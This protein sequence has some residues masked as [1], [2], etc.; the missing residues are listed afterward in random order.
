MSNSRTHV[1]KDSMECSVLFKQTHSIKA[2]HWGKG[3]EIRK[4]KI[5]Y[6]FFPKCNMLPIFFI[7]LACCTEE[8][9]YN[10][11]FNVH[12]ICSHL[13]FYITVKCRSFFDI[14][15]FLF[16]YFPKHES[17]NQMAFNIQN[18]FKTEKIECV[19]LMF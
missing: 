10:G 2:V 3:W 18:I 7:V 12:V 14:I 17:C 13:R 5:L 15:R 6:C 9:F 4:T 1:N 19:T 16:P 11:L 8:L